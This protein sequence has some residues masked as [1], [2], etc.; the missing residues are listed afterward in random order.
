MW[1]YRISSGELLHDGA[2]G[3][4][5]YGTGYSGYG[6]AKNDVNA[7]NQAGIGPIPLGVY[8]IG[9]SFESDHSGPNT[10]RLIPVTPGVNV[11]GRSG[12]ELHGDARSHP[13]FASHG[14]ICI[15]PEPRARVAESHD[16]LLVVMS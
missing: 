3:L 7:C 8:W 5:L 12:F 10:M 6:A 15:G 1:V 14:C 4:K 13:G 11:F 16:R 9:E 2:D